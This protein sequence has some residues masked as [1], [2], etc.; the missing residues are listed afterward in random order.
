MK[1]G[2]VE[3][4]CPPLKSLLYNMAQRHF[5]GKGVDHPKIR[6]QFTQ[7][8]L[9]GSD[10]YQNRL[11]SQ[12]ADERSLLQQHLCRLREFG[13]RTGYHSEARRL[14]IGGKIARAEALLSTSDQESS[15]QDLVGTLGRD[16]ALPVL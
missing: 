3:D 12:R 4:A 10:Y 6:S 1:D 9:L 13:D 16:P 11:R 2:S 5:E 8:W 15:L 7:E 14:E